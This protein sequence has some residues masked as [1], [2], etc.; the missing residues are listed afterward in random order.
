MKF[1]ALKDFN[2]AL[3]HNSNRLD[4]IHRNSH[5]FV[6]DDNIRKGWD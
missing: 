2:L 6:Q 4:I 5:H 3:G 1:R